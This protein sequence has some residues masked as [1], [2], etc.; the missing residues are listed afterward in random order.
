PSSTRSGSGTRASRGAPRRSPGPGA[1]GGRAASPRSSRGRR[2]PASSKDRGLAEERLRLGEEVRHRLHAVARAELEQLRAVR[3]D[4]L[5]VH[6]RLAGKV[7]DQGGELAEQP[8][9]GLAPVEPKT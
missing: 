9:G 6:R 2:S 7:L 3:G 5:D 8:G 4:R 1:A